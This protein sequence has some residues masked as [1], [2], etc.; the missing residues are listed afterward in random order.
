ME[1]I[2]GIKTKYVLHFIIISIIFLILVPS[3]SVL[4][5]INGGSTYDIYNTSFLFLFIY[6]LCFMVYSYLTK[7]RMIKYG[8]ILKNISDRSFH[9]LII[10]THIAGSIISIAFILYY[11]IILF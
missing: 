11:L 6:L 1:Y 7:D 4:I 3:I 5:N 8:F 2:R 9:I 10:A